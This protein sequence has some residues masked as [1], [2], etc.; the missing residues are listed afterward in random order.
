MVR[1]TCQFVDVVATIPMSLASKTESNVGGSVEG[2]QC[3]GWEDSETSAGQ[4]HLGFKAGL[5]E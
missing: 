3:Q 5:L 4:M 1:T 2:S